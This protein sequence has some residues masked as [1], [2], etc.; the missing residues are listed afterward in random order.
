MRERRR[1]TPKD[2]EDTKGG[3]RGTHGLGDKPRDGGPI[4]S[5]EERTNRGLTTEEAPGPGPND[6]GCG[7]IRKS[8]VRRGKC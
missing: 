5:E 1:S 2:P 4:D 3:V 8:E 6:K 7:S